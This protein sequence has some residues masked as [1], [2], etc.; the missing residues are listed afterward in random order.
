MWQLQPLRWSCERAKAL[1]LLGKLKSQMK[2][3]GLACCGFLAAVLKL[4]V[5]RS[6]IGG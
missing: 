3:I 1:I 5:G 4:G 2:G 6:E